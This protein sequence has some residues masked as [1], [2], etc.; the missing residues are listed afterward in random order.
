ML[1]GAWTTKREDILDKP[2]SYIYEY[3]R[4]ISK[5]LASRRQRGSLVSVEEK[6]RLQEGN[7]GTEFLTAILQLFRNFIGIMLSHT[8][9]SSAADHAKCKS[10]F[11]GIAEFQSFLRKKG[12]G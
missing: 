4:H 11:P 8:Q 6:Q 5:F 2:V 1:L 10:F 7:R 9:H 3:P 12:L